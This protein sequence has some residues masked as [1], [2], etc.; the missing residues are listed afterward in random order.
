MFMITS[1]VRLGEAVTL[2][3]NDVRIDPSGEYAVVSLKGRRKTGTGTKNVHSRTTFINREAVESPQSV[4][5]SKGKIP[6]IYYWSQPGRFA[7][8]TPR[9]DNRV[10]PFG[11]NN[12]ENIIKTALKKAGLF[13]KDEDTGRATI[14]YHLFRKYFVTNMTYGGVGDKY[15]D[16]FTGHINA[17]DRAYNKPTTGTLLEIYM[18]G[19]PYL[20]IYDESALEIAKTR[21]E[22]KETKD[23]V[24]DMQLEHL[25]TKS[26]VD[27]LKE[28]N[29]ILRRQILT[30]EES[31]AHEKSLRDQ[32][33]RDPEFI[34]MRKAAEAAVLKQYQKVSNS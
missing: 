4:A 34:A 9:S 30:I 2:T 24:R 18:R 28:K 29:E 20:R 3:L 33:E 10:F 21:E 11:K 16:F 19:E 31:I 1:G 13:K 23:R 17:L 25:M 15:V 8:K 22:I 27:D 26:K 5:S 6:E 32:V 12:A 7:V 14:H